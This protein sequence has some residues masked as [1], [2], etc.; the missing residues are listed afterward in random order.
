MPTVG[1]KHFDYTKEGKQKARA[2]AEMTGKPMQMNPKK[3]AE[4]DKVK[5]PSFNE[6]FADARSKGLKKFRWND[7]IYNT[8]KKGE[9]RVVESLDQMPNKKRS[10]EWMKSLT[11]DQRARLL[12]NY[13]HIGLDYSKVKMGEI[14]TKNADGTFKYAQGGDIPQY[15]LGGWLKKRLTP[16]KKAK[17]AA[18]D[19][20]N[21]E[22]KPI[23]KQNLWH[24]MGSV[25]ALTDPT[26]LSSIATCIGAGGNYRN[27]V[28]RRQEKGVSGLLGKAR[29]KLFPSSDQILSGTGTGYQGDIDTDTGVDVTTG[30]TP[31]SGMTEAEYQSII[32]EYTDNTTFGEEGPPGEPLGGGDE[33]TTEPDRRA[34]PWLWMKG[35]EDPS[36][37]QSLITQMLADK[38]PKEMQM[39]G[40]IGMG[41]MMPGRRM[42]GQN[43]QRK[44][45]PM[46]S[47]PMKRR[48]QMQT[49]QKGMPMRGS[50]GLQPG[51][52]LM[53]KKGGMPKG[54]HT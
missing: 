49:S 22:V 34:K 51:N 12:T 13:G 45:P 53:F 47:Q 37:L 10:D 16:S 2:W 50:K 9:P 8:R 41:S 17:K 36:N 14:P 52:P 31:E 40:Q 32:D 26:N 15:G 18:K 29:D 39:G 38:E 28:E 4:G 24:G 7:K 23:G 11:P 20:W 1:R 42:Y 3:Y 19:W 48:P 35:E 27:C 43:P 46:Q 5:E 33:T 6:A 21:K 30:W 54:Y 25:L 44:R